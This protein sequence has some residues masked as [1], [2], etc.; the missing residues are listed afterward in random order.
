MHL[1]LFRSWPAKLLEAYIPN[2]INVEFDICDGPPQTTSTG[3]HQF[4]NK[5]TLNLL[6]KGKQTIFCNK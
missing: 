2:V 3:W 4:L 5:L 6:N 1:R